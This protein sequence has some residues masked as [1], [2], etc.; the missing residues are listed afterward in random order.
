MNKKI[1]VV[2]DIIGEREVIVEALEDAGFEVKSCRN[3]TDVF[4]IIDG[5]DT[6]FDTVILDLL[7]EG[8]FESSFNLIDQLRKSYA[9]TKIIIL[10]SHGT[11]EHAV[12]AIKAGAFDFADK[13]N[14]YPYEKSDISRILLPKI[15]RASKTD[16]YSKVRERKRLLRSFSEDQLIDLILI[17]LLKNMGYF[18][19]QRNAF[20]GPGEHGKDILPF[21]KYGDF[22]ERIYY[23]AQVKT[24]S[25]SAISGSKSNVHAL[26]DQVKS[27]LLLSFIDKYDGSRKKIDHCLVCFTGKLSND[28]KMILEEATEGRRNIIIV[29]S[30]D[31]LNLLEKWNLSIYFDR[32]CSEITEEK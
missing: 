12:R 32:I 3:A 19:V 24:G 21:Y 16:D 17:P 4:S 20:H 13:P 31:L 28:A 15:E 26:L 22:Y 2:E 7:L 10:T 8:G 25:I 9:T 5:E 29:N 18:G 11:S 27:V 30:D 14:I 6:Y 23:A 1:L